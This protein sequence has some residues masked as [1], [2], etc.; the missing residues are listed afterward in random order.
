MYNE[1]LIKQLNKLIRQVST[2]MHLH[3]VLYRKK[4]AIKE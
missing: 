4:H 1:Y 2:H 3:E